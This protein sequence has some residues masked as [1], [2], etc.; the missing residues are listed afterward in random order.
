MSVDDF[1]KE[2]TSITFCDIVPRSFS[3][4]RAETAWTS[5]TAGGMGTH[6]KA[7]PQLLMR[8]SQKCHITISL[9]Q[10]DTRMQFSPLH[11][12]QPLSKDDFYNLWGD[13]SRVGYDHAMIFMIFKGSERKTG[14]R[15]LFAKS[16]YS[17][18]R[19]LTLTLSDVEPGD[20]IIVPSLE[21][22]GVQM[23]ARMRFWSSAPVELIDTK[24]GK[25]WQVFDASDDAIG[26]QSQPL[27]QPNVKLPVE[28]PCDNQF[29]PEENMHVKRDPHHLKQ[30][31]VLDTVKSMAA[32]A[33]WK[34]G[35]YAPTKWE[36]GKDYFMGAS[37]QFSAGEICCVMRP[38]KSLRFAK[39][40]R[41][42]GE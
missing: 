21:D 37:S 25:D 42:C 36:N 26:G 22:A 11:T 30:S 7:N 9:N 31:G 32:M 4:L 24:G 8:V 34:I 6:W 27:P 29:K 10:P 33:S 20:Y 28:K 18:V 3:V 17:A 19:T 16:A 39:V 35:D 2:F 5:T 13:G 38:D 12:D 1:T 14:M 40:E 15:N 41:D 23:K